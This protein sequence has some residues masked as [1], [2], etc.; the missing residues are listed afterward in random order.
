[1]SADSTF[2]RVGPFSSV[3]EL[4]F[5]TTAFAWYSDE[6]WS[7]FEQFSKI[8][9]MAF[10]TIALIQDRVKLRYLFT[11]EALSI[12]FYGLKGAYGV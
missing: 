10:V 6:G 9:F 8:I 7:A 5:V 11:V 12:G 3:L 2:R 4:T 1:M